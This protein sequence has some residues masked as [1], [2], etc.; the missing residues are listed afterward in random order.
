MWRVI[1]GVSRKALP[2]RSRYHSLDYI[3]TPVKIGHA[4]ER[5]SEREG[6][7]AR[8][9]RVFE[10]ERGRSFAPVPAASEFSESFTS[11]HIARALFLP[12]RKTPPLFSPA[13]FRRRRSRREA[14]SARGRHR[15]L[16][17]ALDEIEIERRA[18]VRV[19]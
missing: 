5:T 10:R 7:S 15:H 16:S 19:I 12:P 17:I 13:D 4:K 18:R 9:T 14:E 1:R 3:G 11:R 2:R 8:E 6:G